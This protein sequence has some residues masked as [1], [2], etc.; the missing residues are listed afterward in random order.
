MRVDIEAKTLD[1]D[2]NR[3]RELTAAQKR[4]MMLALLGDRLGLKSHNETRIMSTYELLV[5]NGGAK[6]VPTRR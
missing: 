2:I 4:T 1:P 3:L 5:G 6:L